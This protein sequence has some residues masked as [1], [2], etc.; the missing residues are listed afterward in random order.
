MTDLLMFLS[1]NLFFSFFS[2]FSS[3]LS[4]LPRA[5]NQNEHDSVSMDVKSTSFKIIIE[6]CL[7][8]RREPEKNA[9]ILISLES[10]FPNMF[11]FIL[12]DLNYNSDKSVMNL[13]AIALYMLICCFPDT[14]QDKVRASMNI[15]DNMEVLMRIQNK[16]F[17]IIDEVGLDGTV[18]QNRLR[19]K[20]RFPD[21]VKL[22]I[23]ELSLR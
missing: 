11:E 12:K 13:A 16:L 14:Y 15:H 7:Q 20:T 2:L 1:S 17:E 6:L 18:N 21:F 3:L 23:K 4:F 22:I 19:F 10:F 8:V 5:K 9:E